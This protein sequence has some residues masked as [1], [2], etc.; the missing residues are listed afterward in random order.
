[1]Q[2]IFG[3]YDRYKGTLIDLEM[4]IFDYKVLKMTGNG[5]LYLMTILWQVVCSIFIAVV[6]GDT[7]FE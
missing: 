1:M 5:V 3:S 4:F 2:Y 6:N 7:N